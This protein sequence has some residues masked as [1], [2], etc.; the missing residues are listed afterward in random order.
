MT[1]EG[2]YV[3]RVRQLVGTL[4]LLV[5]GVTLVVEDEERRVLL[6]RRDDTGEWSLPGGTAEE[7][8]GFADTALRELAEECGLE[9]ERG[10]LH[11]FAA[12]SDPRYGR[13]VY[14]DGSVMYGFTLCFQVLRWR[15]EPRCRDGE[16]LELRFF[17]QDA[18]PDGLKV[19]VTRVLELLGQSL[20]EGRFVTS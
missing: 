20:E 12:L 4:P 3:W 17:A 5:P 2:S 16:S 9:V 15:G 7:G 8:D 18:L 11:P 1:Y 14:P 6:Q 10:D 19:Q 13:L